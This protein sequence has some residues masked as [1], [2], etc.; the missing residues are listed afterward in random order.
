MALNNDAI[1]E[2]SYRLILNPDLAREYLSDQWR[3]AVLVYPQF[4]PKAVGGAKRIKGDCTLGPLRQA[5]DVVG[6]KGGFV[7]HR[8]TQSGQRCIIPELLPRT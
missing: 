1:L 2:Q 3:F 5:V 8:A 7:V 4:M 6:G